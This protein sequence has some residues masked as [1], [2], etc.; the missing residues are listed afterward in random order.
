MLNEPVVRT[1]E[2]T[3]PRVPKSSAWKKTRKWV[4]GG[5]AVVL[6]LGAGLV[7]YERTRSSTTAISASNI[8]KVSYGTVV[9]TISASGT[10]QPKTTVNLSFVGGSG[11]LKTLNVKVGDKVKAGQVLATLDDSN[12]QIQL[13]QAKANMVQAQANL[14]QAQA[15][16]AQTTEGPTPG[17]LAAAQANVAKAEAALKG[18]QQQYEDQLALFNDP[19]QTQQ[20]LISAQ[21]QVNQAKAALD[22]AIANQQNTQ[23]NQQAQLQSDQAK[24]Q[25]DQANLATAQQN[26]QMAQQQYGNI[27]QQQV[28]EAYQNYQNALASYQSW[29]QKGYPGNNPYSTV[30]STTQTIYNSLNNGYNTLQQAQQAYNQAAAQVAQD[31]AQIAKDQTNDNSSVQQAQAQYDAAVKNLQ[32]VQAAIN[33]KTQQKQ[34]L[35]SLQNQVVQA[36]A[37]LQSAQAALQQLQQP[38][39]PA[40][41]QQAQAAVQSAEAGVTTAQAQLQTAEINEANTVLKAPIDGV[42]TATNFNPGENVSG[43]VVAMQDS[44]QQDLQIN[45]QVPQSNIGSIRPDDAVTVTVPAYPNKTYSGKVLQVYPTPQVVQNVTEYTVIASVDNSSG[46]LKPGMSANVSIQT[47]EADHVLTVP[48]ISLVQIGS[49]EGVLVVGTPPAN[50]TTEGVRRNGNAASGSGGE[51]ANGTAGSGGPSGTGSAASGSQGSGRYAGSGGG[52]FGTGGGTRG[53]GGNTGRAQA[54]GNL[55]NLFKNLPPGV[56]FQPVQVGL[57]GT[58][59]VEIKSGLTEGEQI[60]MVPPSLNG[61]SSSSS[62]SGRSG[63][64]GGFGFPGLGGGGAVRM[65]GGG[66]G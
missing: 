34:Q 48:A 57:F 44:D 4:A 22:A 38:P 3:V 26:L 23:A 51:P 14:A 18:A 33:D 5:A 52:T 24:L 6:V 20:Q 11:V 59:T 46:D 8:Y 45:I 47:A 13:Q 50:G 60:L 58:R 17:D 21:N 25:Q 49:V 29:Q 2:A 28:Q 16:L 53:G 9:Q 40:T 42:I 56:Y 63:G 39:D 37:N 65:G 19:T 15:K 36:Q 27:T 1:Q 54:G 31:N 61:T 41:V 66:R 32:A 7:A 30:L 62:S 43:A 10:I 35:D 55:Q 64:V 12:A